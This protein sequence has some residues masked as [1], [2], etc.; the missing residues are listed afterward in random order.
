MKLQILGGLWPIKSCESW[1][2][3]PGSCLL[4]FVLCMSMMARH[5]Q[6]DVHTRIEGDIYRLYNILMGTSSPYL[7]TIGIARSI[8]RK[9]KIARSISISIA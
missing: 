7:G 9:K 2:G 4:P 8:E 3:N 1:Y 5:L 6:L